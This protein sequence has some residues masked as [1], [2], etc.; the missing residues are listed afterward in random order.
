M[1][2]FIEW[3]VFSFVSPSIRVDLVPI[4]LVF[5][6]CWILSFGEIPE[7]SSYTMLANK[8]CIKYRHSCF[9]ANC[10]VEFTFTVLGNSACNTINF[11]INVFVVKAKTFDFQ[12]LTTC[13]ITCI[14]TDVENYR[15][16]LRLVA[17][18]VVCSA[19]FHVEIMLLSESSFPKHGN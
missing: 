7:L 13:Q 19:S 8:W 10:A 18:R 17:L 9:V 11:N 2:L 3:W 6:G 4:S 1:K 12:A 15:N 14:L 16:C 5:A